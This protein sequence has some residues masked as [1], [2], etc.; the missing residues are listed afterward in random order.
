MRPAFGLWSAMAIRPM[1]KGDSL[2]VADSAMI[3]RA[4]GLDAFIEGVILSW[5]WRRR[6]IAFVS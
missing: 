4:N 3:P 6:A 5:G 1:R 2:S